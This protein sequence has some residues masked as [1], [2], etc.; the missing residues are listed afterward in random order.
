MAMPTPITLEI[1]KT[2]KVIRDYQGGLWGWYWKPNDSYY[3]GAEIEVRLAIGDEI[4]IEK[5]K[6]KN[7]II[8]HQDHDSYSV[9]DFD[10]DKL[11]L[12]LEET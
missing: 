9:G 1:G 12:C 6:N 7:V 2:Y 11:S 3:G 10:L 5:I 4:K 8:N